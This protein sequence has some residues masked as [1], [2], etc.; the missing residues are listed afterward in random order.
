M[1]EHSHD[2]HQ[3]DHN[4]DHPHEHTHSDYVHTEHAV[5]D[6]GEEIGALIIYTPKELL[7]REIEV[8]PPGV[9]STRTHTAVLERKTGQ[10]TL[11]AAL[12]LALPVGDYIIWKSASE[13]AGS[14]SIKGGEVAE[15][16]WLKL[17]R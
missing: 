14:V 13:P 3:Y 8:S 16:N 5:L 6:I 9:N 15:V 11:F 17:G 7:G 10:N 2:H 1:A 4:H 12:Y